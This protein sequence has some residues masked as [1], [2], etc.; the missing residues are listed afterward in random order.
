MVSKVGERE[1]FGHSG[2]YPGHITLS[3]VDAEHRLA[4]TVLTNAIDGP[5]RQLTEAAFKL[6]DLAESK[7][8]GSADALDRFT[9]RYANLW[10][11]MDVVKLGG[12]L[13]AIDPSAPDPAAEP[14]TLE[15]DGDALRITGGSGYGAYGETYRFT[16]GPDGAVESVRGSSGLSRPIAAFTLP[17]RVRVGSVEA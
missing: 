17:E 12:R 13:Y 8:R 14:T 10:G 6:L 2:G 7:P 1:L 15:P 4:V 5:A 16:F 11:V 3:L 9:G